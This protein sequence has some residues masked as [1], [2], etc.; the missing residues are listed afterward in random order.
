MPK[1]DPNCA[2]LRAPW[3]KIATELLVGRMVVQARYLTS[4]E[5]KVLGWSCGSI[6]LEFDNGLV[7]Y[8]S[9]DDEGN[10][11]G[12]MFTSHAQHGTLPVCP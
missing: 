6:V 11:P 2:A 8:P 3:E 1:T 4:D 12:A 9:A 7:V 10:G 5:Q